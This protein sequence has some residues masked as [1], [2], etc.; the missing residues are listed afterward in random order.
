MNIFQDEPAARGLSL[1]GEPLPDFA[2]PIS[3]PIGITPQRR[4]VSVRRTMSIDVHWPDGRSGAGRFHGR[5]R[6]ALTLQPDQAMLTIAD[7][8]VDLTAAQRE[9]VGISASP[10]PKRLQELVGVRAGNYLRAALEDL[11]PGEK[12]AGTPL[13][14]LLD[15]MAG[16]TL[17]SGWAF[18]QWK[19]PNDPGRARQMPKMQGICMGFRPGSSAL[20]ERGHA[21]PEQN[22]TRVM[23]L[24]DPDDLAGWHELPDLGG[25]N[26]RRARRIDVWR[27]GDLLQV[28]SH[29]QDSASAPDGGQRLAVHE[30][31]VSATLGPDG[32]LEHI[33]AR[34]GTLPYAACRVAPVNLEVLVG[35]P[36]RTLRAEVLQ[37]LKLT[38]GCTHLNDMIRSLAEVPVLA[39][40]LP[41]P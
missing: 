19:D 31:L 9:I 29:F 7:A 20:D 39:G 15:D 33:E 2:S 11:F 30:Y 24:V 40:H 23:P 17:V 8:T 1:L 13:Y 21:R 32:V 22:S 16:A 25:V 5:A 14:L 3:D 41:A 37:R 34:P 27:D 28:E 36:A 6:D 12:D 18:S 4:A 26:F 10:E 35:T 38:G